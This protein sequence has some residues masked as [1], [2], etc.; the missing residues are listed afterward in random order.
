MKAVI[1]IDP[2]KQ[3]AIVLLGIPGSA[4]AIV[5][6][7]P[8]IPAKKGV[9][10]D[11]PA[12]VAILKMFDADYPG[13]LVCIEK[14]HAMP[15]QGVTSM[16]SMGEGYGL[17]RGMVVALGMRLL[18]VT[19]QAWMKEV[20]A[21]YGTKD[22]NASYTVASRLFPMAPLKGPKGGIKD[23]RADALCIA[24]YGRRQLFGSATTHMP[25]ASS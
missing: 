2:G 14:V 9:T 24:E 11:E 8:V 3:G 10:Y 4:G 15:K 17:W 20:L 5:S 13:S 18:L 25:D 21:G 16:F 12:M 1:G 22:K 23:G 7:T 6:D 19:P